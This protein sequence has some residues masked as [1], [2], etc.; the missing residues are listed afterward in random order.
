MDH[1]RWTILLLLERD[2]AGRG[3]AH[4]LDMNASSHAPNNRGVLVWDK[5]ITGVIPPRIETYF[6]YACDGMVTVSNI[7][8]LVY[9][10]KRHHFKFWDGWAGSRYWV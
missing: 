3:L 6:D 2:T 4:E 10:K 5:N 1:N 9:G 7:H 8:N